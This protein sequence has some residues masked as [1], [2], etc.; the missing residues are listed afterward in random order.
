MMP[1]PVYAVDAMNNGKSVRLV[2]VKLP[3]CYA[4]RRELGQREGAAQ[5]CLHFTQ[6]LWTFSIEEKQ[7]TL[8][9]NLVG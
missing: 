8:E 3:I 5:E 4:Y 7:R 9:A 2:N 6:A 1:H